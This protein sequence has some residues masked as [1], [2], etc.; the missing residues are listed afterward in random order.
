MKNPNLCPVLYTHDVAEHIEVTTLHAIIN[1]TLFASLFHYRIHYGVTSAR[2]HIFC[3]LSQGHRG[4]SLVK[5]AFRKNA[6]RSS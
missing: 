6:Y 1:I 2:S 5:E 4:Q 3:N